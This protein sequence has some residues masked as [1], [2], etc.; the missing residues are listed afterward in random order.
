MY[1]KSNFEEVHL[2]ALANT[3]VCACRIFSIYSKIIQKSPRENERDRRST[4]H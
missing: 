3:H 4:H 1:Q 2:S